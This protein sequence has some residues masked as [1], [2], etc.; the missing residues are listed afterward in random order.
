[1]GK[2]LRFFA[3]G[4][5]LS[6]SLWLVPR[7]EAAPPDEEETPLTH[8][9]ALNVATEDEPLKQQ[10]LKVNDALRQIYEQMVQK[11]KA[12]NAVPNEAQKASLYAELDGLRK[13]RDMLER[14]LHDLVEE[15]RATEWTQ[16]DAA[17][18][19][20]KAFERYQERAYQKEEVL[21]ERRQQ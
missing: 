3:L 10:I 11:R 8:E 2:D 1:M 4:V 18:K 5:L 19:R 6:S 14:L 15:A 13:E 20:A 17:L 12:L 21:R 16:I 7:L 9:E